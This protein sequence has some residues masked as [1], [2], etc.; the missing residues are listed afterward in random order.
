MTAEITIRALRREDHAEWS[1]MWTAYL[2][3]Y[4]TTL[5][6]AVYETAF[7]R[8]LIEDTREFQ[9]FIAEMEG[10]PVGLA[11]FLFHRL[12]WSEEDTC[13]LLDLYTDPAARGKGVARALIN[14]VHAAAKKEGIVVTYWTTQDDNYKGRMLYDQVAT[15][16]PLIVYE[17][18]D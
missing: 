13:Y 5:S 9:G 15:R 16:T 14:A 4:R 18:S 12:L 8:L 7:A 11:H 2:E 1:R 17:K 3:F 6:E 10:R